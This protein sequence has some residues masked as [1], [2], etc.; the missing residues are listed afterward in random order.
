MI[1]SEREKTFRVTLFNSQITLSQ[2][3]KIKN[4]KSGIK[5][6]VKSDLLNSNS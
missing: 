3:K 5:I 4:K 6:Y 2:Y 1:F